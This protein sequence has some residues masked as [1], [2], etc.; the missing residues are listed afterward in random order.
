LEFKGIGIKIATMATNILARRFKIPIA[1]YI[2]LDISP[3][4]HVKRVF[5]RLGFIPKDAGNDELVSCARELSTKHPGAFD[6][7]TWKIGKSWC[8]PKNQIVRIVI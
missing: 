5:K 2:Y 8:H 4:V 3:D 6:F 1:D 7:P